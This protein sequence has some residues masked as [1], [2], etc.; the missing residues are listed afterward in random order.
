MSSVPTTFTSELFHAGTYK[1][2]QGRLVR[3]VT[4]GSVWLAFALAAWRLYAYL[5]GS[6]SDDIRWLQWGGPFLVLAGGLW[7]GY[8][9][10]QWPRFADFLIAV[11]AELKKV[12]WPTRSELRRAS[13]VVIF[14][15][16][17]LA[18]ALFGFDVLWQAIFR[19]IGITT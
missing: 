8:R 16:F 4:C 15:I 5:A 12:S 10:V 11:E 18:L 1:P 7:I 9:I 13:G 19:L 17:F 14:T 3:Q 2:T 6:L